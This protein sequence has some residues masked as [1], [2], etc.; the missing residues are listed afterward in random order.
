MHQNS[1]GLPFDMSL[2]D[3]YFIYSAFP[4]ENQVRTNAIQNNLLFYSGPPFLPN[5]NSTQASYPLLYHHRNQYPLL[6][7]E[8][9]LSMDLHHRVDPTSTWLTT[10]G[11]S[12]PSTREGTHWESIS[13][14]DSFYSDPNHLDDF[15]LCT[16]F[17]L[18]SLN[19]RLTIVSV[20]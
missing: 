11:S 9:P 16:W 17:I 7:N 13:S 5:E 12:S 6:P 15:T 2:L 1:P 8:E 19:V 14:S 10:T 18:S 3:S 4:N 20:P